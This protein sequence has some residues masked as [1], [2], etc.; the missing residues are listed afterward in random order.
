MDIFFEVPKDLKITS[1][2][3][4][5]LYDVVIIGAGPAGMTAT[6]YCARK[7]LDTLLV[8]KDIGGQVIW[9]SGIENYMGYQYITG[10]ELSEKFYL[11]IGQF[12]IS[13]LKDIDI[14]K[15]EV[16]EDKFA[17]SCGKS[18]Y[19]SKSIIIAS[20][21]RN[22]EL[23]VSGE[24]EFLGRGVAY[25]SVCDAPLFKDKTVAVIGG[26]NSAMTAAIDLIS[27]VSKLYIINIMDNLQGDEVLLERIKS[28]NKVEIILSSEAL[29]I[30]G[31][32]KVEG[33]TVKNRKTSEIREIYLNGVFIE[34]GL[35]PNT[36]FVDK[37]L[38]V[39]DINEIVVDC[40][41]RTSVKGIFAC[42]DVTSI[43]DKQIIIACGEGAKA[44]LSAHRYLLGVK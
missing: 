25:C 34:V 30:N 37:V 3:S 24:K 10:S 35:I 7:K 27:Y 4:D 8:T 1:P 17:V 23:G 31:K 22:R 40:N 6:V 19:Y 43:L 26:G 44:A 13:L 16:L 18:K 14:C 42:G 38:S 28:S 32:D 20:G 21:K 41:C 33:I 39:N 12:P 2:S 9:T 29:K 11:Q 36:E 15:L 5:K